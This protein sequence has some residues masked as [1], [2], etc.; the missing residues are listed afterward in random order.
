MRTNKKSVILCIIGLFMLSACSNTY[1][2]NEE[3]IQPTAE[4]IAKPFGA[5]PEPKVSETPKNESVLSSEES[6]AVAFE[7]ASVAE[8][9]PRSCFSVTAEEFV[10]AF[11]SA[12]PSMKIELN[13]YGSHSIFGGGMEFVIFFLK[14]G[15]EIK[16]SKGDSE[17]DT[18][19]IRVDD[20]VSYQKTQNA[21][22]LSVMLV[23][24]RAAAI[25]D[26][27]FSQDE[28]SK[29]GNYTSDGFSAVVN[30][31]KYSYRCYSS[32]LMNIPSRVY[33]FSCEA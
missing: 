30:G 23:G 25:L 14:D 24:Y 29:N 8:E 33:E 4:I 12:Y 21:V 2:K 11:N 1:V 26:P 3:P 6:P 9:L 32:N 7:D 27:A 10:K 13:P 16:T 17:F 15:D 18:L 31:I 5:T 20:Q 22:Y 28:Y 19:I